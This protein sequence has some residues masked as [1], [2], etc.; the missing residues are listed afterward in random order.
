MKSFNQIY[1]ST[2]PS[3]SEMLTMLNMGPEK[4]QSLHVGGKVRLKNSPETRAIIEEFFTKDLGG[5]PSEYCKVKW[6]I[7]PEWSNVKD[8][9]HIDNFEQV[10]F[11]LFEQILKEGLFDKQPKLWSE[12]GFDYWRESD[13]HDWVKT[14]IMRGTT[15]HGRSY[16]DQSVGDTHLS[17]KIDPGKSPRCA[18][19]VGVINRLKKSEYSL[20]EIQDVMKRAYIGLDDLQ[21]ERVVKYVK[22]S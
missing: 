9:M 3:S 22:D 17:P 5:T 7:K 2:L 18:H 10:P 15:D 16:T 20:E 6:L 14:V 19:W 1:E 11:G 4:R 13:V 12:K 21:I 8:E